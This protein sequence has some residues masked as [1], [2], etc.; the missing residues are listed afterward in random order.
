METK[1]SVKTMAWKY[2]VKP[3]ENKRTLDWRGKDKSKMSYLTIPVLA[4]YRISSR[5]KVMAGPYFHI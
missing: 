2:S 4:N 3:E 1:A 5:W